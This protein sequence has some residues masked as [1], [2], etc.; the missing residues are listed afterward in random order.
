LIAISI[1]H[2]VCADLTRLGDTVENGLNLD[3]IDALN[4]YLDDASIRPPCVRAPNPG[5]R[6]PPSGLR[7]RGSSGNSLHVGARRAGVGT[8]VQGSLS[9]RR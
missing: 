2:L 3:R 7:A 5:G 4:P 8:G 1:G 9:L 6:E